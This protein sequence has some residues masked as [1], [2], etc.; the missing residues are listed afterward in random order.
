MKNISILFFLLFSLSLSAQMGN[1]NRIGNQNNTSYSDKVSIEEN[2]KMKSEKMNE[3]MENLKSKLTLD[4]LQ[5]I[6]IKNELA[7]NYRTIDILIKKEVSSD[8]KN[9]QL[10]YL[11]EKNDT[12]IISYLNAEQK[13]KYTKFKEDF[14]TKKPDKKKKK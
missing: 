5:F 2:E 9:E 10:K 7:A 1:Q 12:I 14:Y 13:E 4:E 8:E 6:A 3:L 11:I